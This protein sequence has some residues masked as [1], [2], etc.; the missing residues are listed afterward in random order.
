MGRQ[1]PLV[2]AIRGRG[3]AGPMRQGESDSSQGFVGFDG[4]VGRRVWPEI[5]H[6]RILLADPKIVYRAE[7]SL[8]ESVRRAMGVS[9]E[10]DPV[11]VQRRLRSEK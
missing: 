6:E 9:D 1:H 5:E 3:S 10:H 8:D 11:H 7:I 4:L 2:T